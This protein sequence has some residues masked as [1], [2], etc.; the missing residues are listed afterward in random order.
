ML[1]LY[2]RELAGQVCGKESV[3][4]EISCILDEEPTEELRQTAL[5]YAPTENLSLA[6]TGIRLLN[7]I[8][9]PPQYDSTK[10]CFT[11]GVDRC[12]EHPD[13]KLPKMTFN[14]AHL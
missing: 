12:L 9:T 5:R 1:K 3:G 13:C 7:T 11:E 4:G 2:G 14:H 6:S 8:D 10:D